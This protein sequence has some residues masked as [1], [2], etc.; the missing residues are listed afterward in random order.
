MSGRFHP[1][2][3][4]ITLV[5]LLPLLVAAPRIWPD[6]SGSAALLLAAS[7][8]TGILAL[9]TMLAA[10]V[11]S[12]RLPRFDALFGGLPRIWQVHTWLGA[13]AF[14]LILMHV[15]LLAFSALPVSTAHS[16]AALFPPLT[17]VTVWAGWIALALTLAFVAPG[18]RFFGN[19]DYQRWKALHLL[20]A[21]A[22]LLGLA[23][24][25]GLGGA[26]ALW[27]G[28]GGLAVAAIVWRK[29][30]SPRLGRH[31]YEVGAVHRLA[32]GV[33]EVE[34]APCGN[35]LRHAP[36]QF[37]YLTPRNPELRA[38]NGEEHPFTL[39]SAPGDANLRIGIKALGDASRAWQDITPGTRVEVE[40]PYGTFFDETSRERPALWFGGGI[41]ITPFVSAARTIPNHTPP[42]PVS[43]VY[44]AN[45][46][47][48]AYYLD[49]L[50]DIAAREAA[51]EVTVHFFNEHGPIDVDFLRQHCPDFAARE[52]HICGP[53]G[54]THHLLGL[55]HR[56]GVPDSRIHTEA[57]EFL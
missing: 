5:V 32:P 20:S 38:G 17:Q 10:A 28:L 22:L 27:W 57:F 16:I 1:G 34:L 52:I 24:G 33:V 21:P 9:S 49:E 15:V 48:R 30:L 53:A 42:Q 35:P 55:L 41:G 40:G 54:M 12:L 6:P 11:L 23:H 36:G 18:F 29:L 46:P 7:Q 8:A 31:A 13:S 39:A 25:M 43:L 47:E 2:D 50:R 37:V 45:R 44:L 51:F 14:M 3:A 56:A 26:P 4:L 19:I